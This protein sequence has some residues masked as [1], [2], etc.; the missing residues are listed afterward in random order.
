MWFSPKKRKPSVTSRVRKLMFDQL[1]ERTLLSLTFLVDP[2]AITVDGGALTA[3]FIPVDNLTIDSDATVNLTMLSGNPVENI[4]IKNTTNNGSLNVSSGIKTIGSVSGNG[5]LTVYGDATLTA[6]SICQNTLTIGAGSRI[7]IAPISSG[8]LP[9]SPTG[10]TP[11]PADMS[12]TIDGGTLTYNSDALP[13]LSTVDSPTLVCT[14]PPDVYNAWRSTSITEG[15]DPI[16]FPILGVD[17]SVATRDSDP[18]SWP[19]Y[20]DIETN[21]QTP[22]TLTVYENR[23]GQTIA[24]N[25]TYSDTKWNGDVSQEVNMLAYDHARDTFYREGEVDSIVEQPNELVV[26]IF[27]S[28][29]LEEYGSIPESTNYLDNT[30][31]LDSNNYDNQYVEMDVRYGTNFFDQIAGGSCPTGSWGQ[32]AGCG[33]GYFEVPPVDPTEANTE[34][35]L[36]G[37]NNGSCNTLSTESDADAGRTK[38]WLCGL[39]PNSRYYVGYGVAI[40][41]G[42][43]ALDPTLK[44]PRGLPS[45][46]V[47]V[48]IDPAIGGPIPDDPIPTAHCA[49]GNPIPNGSSLFVY[50]DYWNADIAMSDSNGKIFIISVRPTMRNSGP[51]MVYFKCHISAGGTLLE[52]NG[53]SMDILDYDCTEAVSQINI[54][55]T[56]KLPLFNNNIQ[57]EWAEI[58]RFANVTLTTKNILQKPNSIKIE[59]NTE[60]EFED[61]DYTK[62]TLSKTNPT[63]YAPSNDDSWL[64]TLNINLLDSIILKELP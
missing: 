23:F 19:P 6:T 20:S 41:T 50:Y 28:E 52:S 10:S 24:V 57:I 45:G 62:I 31:A 17:G 60:I 1:E 33:D 47:S 38:V 40:V 14:D 4:S 59:N 36:Y 53:M 44:R 61:D 13:N 49:S 39:K 48:K 18:S 12:A 25:Q 16:L 42:V 29:S 58:E 32:P 64:Q 22:I 43:T 2:S 11:A 7:T 54:S 30:T 51:G 9:P 56:D 8:T 37:T 35:V 46:G 15:G 55:I 21:Y 63:D 27:Q 34:V 26:N 3:N 5:D